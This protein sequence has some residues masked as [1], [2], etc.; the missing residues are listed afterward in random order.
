MSQL[1]VNEKPSLHVAVW[2]CGILWLERLKSLVWFHHVALYQLVWTVSTSTPCS[3][4][5]IMIAKWVR[6]INGVHTAM[7]HQNKLTPML[8]ILNCSPITVIENNNWKSSSFLLLMRNLLWFIELNEN[9]GY[10]D[11]SHTNDRDTDKSPYMLS[12]ALHLP[13]SILQSIS[14]RNHPQFIAEWLVVKWYI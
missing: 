12:F 3:G 8:R 14:L 13:C 7:H 6:F 1:T 5:L 10:K 11:D 4:K 2:G 9:E